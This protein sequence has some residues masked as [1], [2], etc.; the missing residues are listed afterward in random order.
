MLE[1]II[2]RI[3]IQDQSTYLKDLKLTLDRIIRLSNKAM[4]AASISGHEGI[5]RLML[6]KGATNYGKAIYS[7]ACAGHEGIVR[8]LES[9][10]K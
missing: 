2:E 7:A 1:Y 9:M 8:L 3:I 6:A 5:V 10:Q 4:R